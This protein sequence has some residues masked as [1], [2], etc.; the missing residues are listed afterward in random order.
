MSKKI[1]VPKFKASRLHAFHN[2]KRRS[3]DVTLERDEDGWWVAEVPSLPGCH[4]QGRSIGQARNRIREAIAVWLDADESNIDV[5]LRLPRALAKLAD[6][7][8]GKRDQAER[9]QKEAAKESVAAAR[10]LTR[11]GISRRDVGEILGV[12]FQRAQQLVDDDA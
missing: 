1:S 3:F 4:T 2:G 6:E 8:R 7:V 12:S 5:N 9:L 11:K 10:K